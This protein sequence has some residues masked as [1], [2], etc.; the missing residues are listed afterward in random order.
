M[1]DDSKRELV[2]GVALGATIGILGNIW[3]TALFN[4]LP[5]DQWTSIGIFFVGIV[6]WIWAF[7]QIFK[8]LEK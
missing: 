8:L 6:V 5:K 3:V 7:I 1:G 4:F 2:I